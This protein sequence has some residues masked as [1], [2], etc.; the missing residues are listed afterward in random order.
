MSDDVFNTS[1]ID[2]V[3]K[4]RKEK[5]EAAGSF[6][7]YFNLGSDQVSLVR[8]LD[9]EPL[10]FHQHRIWDP[11]LKDGAGAWRNLTC[12]RLNCPECKLGGKHA[13]RYVGAYRLIHIDH[14]EKDENGVE[15]QEPTEKIF[16]KGINTLEVLVR[17]NRRKP[18]S[19]E[20]ME[21]ERIGTGFNTKYIFDGTGDTAAIVDY[22]KPD[23]DDLKEIFK[24]Q[25]DVLERLAKD[26]AKAQHGGQAPEPA[27]TASKPADEP[28]KT[29]S[30]AVTESEKSESPTENEV[31]EVE[32]VVD[33]D[34][35]F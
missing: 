13:P 15:K 10:T 19:Q 30:K 22:K 6:M 7:P 16:L 18:L 11:M 20:N 12:P 2:E 27:K 4:Q 24:V 5:M 21:V 23:S 17:K 28:V 34:I 14:V 35:P 26:G 9:N 31:D 32:D 1:T 25:R 3:S 29:A 33:D 8:F